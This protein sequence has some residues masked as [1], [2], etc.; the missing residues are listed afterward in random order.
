MTGDLRRY[1]AANA[2]ARALLGSLLG[3]RGLEA[4][5]G[6]P[7]PAALLDALARTPYGVSPGSEQVPESAVLGRL[8]TVGRA[9]LRLLPENERAFV[10]AYLLQ[11]EVANLKLLIRAVAAELSWAQVAPYVVALPGIAT[12]DVHT[13]VEARGLRELA[14]RLAPT[15]YG[16]A[17]RGALHRL[18][19]AGAFALEVALELDFYERLWAAADTLRPADTLR[20]RRLLG[21][22]FDVLNLNWIARYRDTLQLSPEEILNYTLRQGR[23]INFPLRR[24]LAEDGSVPWHVALARTPYARLLE[25][26][27]HGQGFD[28]ASTRLWRFLGAEALQALR[29]YPFHIGVLLAFL[30]TQS[31]ELRDVQVLLA[32]KSLAQPAAEVFGQLA[33]LRP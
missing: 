15:P 23:W 18:R 24:Q 3:R 8:A 14:D 16:S 33:T 10:R 7:T 21:V 22:L 17:L 20:A 27:P 5:Y 29:G 2:R 28:A 25:D 13:L 6:Y 11:H 26:V 32:A 30:I 4:L 19:E 31:I 1:A 12:V 9:L